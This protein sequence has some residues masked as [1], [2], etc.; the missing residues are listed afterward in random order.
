MKVVNH[1]VDRAMRRLVAARMRPQTRYCAANTALMLVAPQRDL[2]AGAVPNVAQLLQ[3]SRAAHLRIIYAPMARPAVNWAA[4]TPSQRAI[5]DLDALR[6]GSP[7]AAIHPKGGAGS[8]CVWRSC[9]GWSVRNAA[10][11][12]RRV[13]GAAARPSR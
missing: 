3:I 12:P 2:L 7:G 8:G 6:A 10:E 5:S 13:Q 9:K 1:V 11:V 4:Q